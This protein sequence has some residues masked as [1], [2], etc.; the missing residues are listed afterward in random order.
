MTDVVLYEVKNRVATLTMNRPQ[1]RNA[2]NHV[3]RMALIEQLDRAL[4]DED[5][6]V[7]V[8]AATAPVFCAGADLKDDMGPDFFPQEELEKEFKPSLMRIAKGGKPV[9]A[10]VNG[11]AAGIGAAY[12]LACDLCVMANDASISMAFHHLGFFPDS[13][14]KT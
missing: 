3:M 10:A 14:E 7:I 12:A 13:W 11:P 5:V 1:A 8:L 9:I 6:R 2:M 4:N